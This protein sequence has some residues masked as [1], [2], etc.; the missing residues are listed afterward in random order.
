MALHPVGIVSIPTIIWSHTRLHISG[1]FKEHTRSFSTC[2]PASRSRY[3]THR[4]NRCRK[5]KLK[6][7][8]EF[9]HCNIDR[10]TYATFQGSGPS[11]RKNVDGFIVPAPTYISNKRIHWW[12]SKWHHPRSH[13]PNDGIFARKQYSDWYNAIKPVRSSMTW[14]LH[15]TS[16]L[17]YG[18]AGF[19]MQK[20]LQCFHNKR[21]VN[22]WNSLELKL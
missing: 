1:T 19:R 14:L 8:Q 7:T 3:K 18:R 21:P 13:F 15:Y 4:E 10:D 9:K 20:P 11:T 5:L 2:F 12:L 6:E 16:K 17:A 22:W